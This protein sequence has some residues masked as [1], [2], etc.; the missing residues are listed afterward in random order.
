MIQMYCFVLNYFKPGLAEGLFFII[1]GAKIESLAQ[2]R[3]DWLSGNRN[4]QQMS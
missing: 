3:I 4:N 2:W 1:A